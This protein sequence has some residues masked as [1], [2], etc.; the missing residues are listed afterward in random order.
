[1]SRFATTTTATINSS[2]RFS[3]LDSEVK[4][5]KTTT[6]AT[7]TT[8]TT[9]PPP[10]VKWSAQQAAAPRG[11]YRP[12]DHRDYR[13]HRDNRGYG[14]RRD[15][16]EEQM[17]PPPPPIN[18]STTFPALVS[19]SAPTT[20]GVWN[21]GTTIQTMY[22]AIQVAQA[23]EQQ[24]QEQKRLLAIQQQH[25][26]QLALA[27]QRQTR[28]LTLRKQDFQHE[29]H[30]EEYDDEDAEDYPK[31]EWTMVERSRKRVTTYVPP[32]NRYDDEEHE[33]CVDETYAAE[34]KHH[35]VW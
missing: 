33:E 6:T 20:A 22:N 3:E 10:R 34:D 25:E 21:R 14:R 18:D 9:P 7:I 13:D 27:E 12:R 24:L 15:T 17:P 31:D 23:R 30:R 8:T 16:P 29:H 19:T 1:M 5:T 4:P 2:N 32:E 11:Q 35:T 28:S 26:M